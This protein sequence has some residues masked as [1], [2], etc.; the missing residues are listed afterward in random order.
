MTAGPGKPAAVRVFLCTYRRNHL[1]PRALRGLLAQTFP[2]WVCELHND[3]PSDPEPAKLAAALG[4]PRIQVVQHVRNLGALATFNLMYQPCAEL[5]VSL[6]E[7]DNWWEPEFLATLVAA[8]ETH[9]EATMAWSNMRRC[10]EQPDGSWTPG[11]TIWPETAG[12]RLIPW[13]QAPQAWRA[14]HSQGAMI[15]RAERLERFVVPAET[16]LDFIEPVRE[17]AFPHPL[18]FVARP[19]AHFA[20]T[21]ATA[22]TSRR[23][24]LSA[25]YVLMLASYF[26]HVQ[27]S[28]AM[29]REMWAEL[30]GLSVRSTDALLLAGFVEPSCRVLWKEASLREWL[31][32]IRAQIRRPAEFIRALRAKSLYPALWRYLDQNTA[33]RSRHLSARSDMRTEG[34]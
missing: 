21:I 9:P 12:T 17:R 27:P 14:M 15:L 24:G 8:L 34:A 23:K 2:D 5:Y 32:L 33:E 13:P 6:L 29:R 16:R 4:D 11:D 10:Q 18:V 7:D 30:R 1:L 28:A 25:H 3:D 31:A 22:R 26:R 20:E 19:L